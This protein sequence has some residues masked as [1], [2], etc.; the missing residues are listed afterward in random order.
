MNMRLDPQQ[1]LKSQ[2][3]EILFNIKIFGSKQKI[4]KF[5]KNFNFS[6]IWKIFSSIEGIAVYWNSNQNKW[7]FFPEAKTNIKKQWQF[8]IYWEI[9]YF[10]APTKFKKFGLFWNFLKN[11][12][13][14][15]Q[16]RWKISQKIC[17]ETKTRCAKPNKFLIHFGKE[18]TKTKELIKQTSQIFQVFLQCQKKIPQ[19]GPFS[20]KQESKSL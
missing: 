15:L 14:F 8:L 10:L 9:K 4:Q 16:L 17:I 19:K 11:V 13:F 20:P 1:G 12:K 7:L 2:K 18:K 6:N 3:I 5:S